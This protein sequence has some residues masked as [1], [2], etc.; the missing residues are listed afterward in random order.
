MSVDL[1]PDRERSP[2]GIDGKWQVLADE[3]EALKEQVK[4]AQARLKESEAALRHAEALIPA[5]VQ[6]LSDELDRVKAQLEDPL[7]AA[8]Q[9]NSDEQ[10][11]MDHLTGVLEIVIERWR[12][13][14]NMQEV[15]SAAH[16]LQSAVVQHLLNRVNPDQWSSW[17]DRKKGAS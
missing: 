10:E 6:S 4:E 5:S 3:R 14:H 11:V 16:T 2:Q 7:S 8:V 17:W 9:L 15:I 13:K 12:M 1:N